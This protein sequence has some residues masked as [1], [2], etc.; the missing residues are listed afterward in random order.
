MFLKFDKNSGKLYLSV[1][2]EEY[3]WKD[4]LD[5]NGMKCFTISDNELIK[6]AKVLQKIWSQKV[7]KYSVQSFNDNLQQTE[8]T[9]TIYEVKLYGDG[10][11]YYWCEGYS[12]YNFD[13]IQ[14]PL[15]VG[16]KKLKGVVYSLLMDIKYD[17]TQVIYK[18]QFLKNLCKN[19]KT[20]LKGYKGLKGYGIDL[21]DLI[22]NIRV[23]KIL[24]IDPIRSKMRAIL[25]MTVSSDDD[26]SEESMENYYADSN[27]EGDNF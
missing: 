18:K 11:G 20:F 27:P 5:D 7:Q 4:E 24:D 16:H 25:H 3:L 21:V 1:Y 26:S 10:P 22:K 14:T 2:S 23:M 19:L 8:I 9:K 13:L 6:E 15:I 12:L 17:T